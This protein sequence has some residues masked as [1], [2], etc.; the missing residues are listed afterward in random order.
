MARTKQQTARKSTAGKA[1]FRLLQAAKAKS[2]SRSKPSEG[3]AVKLPAS[4]AAATPAPKRKLAKRLPSSIPGRKRYVPGSYA[5]RD[6]R[7]YQQ[8]TELLI[9]KLPFQ[10]LVRSIAARFHRDLRFQ[11][12]AVMAMQVSPLVVGVLSSR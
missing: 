2:L 6:I 1:P 4:A 11:S 8:S 10:R 3:E 7:R 5:L 12:S 9:R